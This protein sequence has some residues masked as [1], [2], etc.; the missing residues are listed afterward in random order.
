M[1]QWDQV[2]QALDEAETQVRV[3]ERFTDRMAKFLIGRLRTVTPHLLQKL[4]R[5]LSEFNSTTKKW[6]S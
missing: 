6:N 4:K 3:V 2:R 5:E 1:N